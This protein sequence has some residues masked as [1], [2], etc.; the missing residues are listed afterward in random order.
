MKRLRTLAIAAFAALALTALA[1][2]PAAAGSHGKVHQHARGHHHR[3]ATLTGPPQTPS[4]Q[5]TSTAAISRLSGGVRPVRIASG[6]T[7][8]AM[9]TGSWQHG[10]DDDDCQA[11]ADTGNMWQEKGDYLSSQGD[12]AGADKAYDS[13]STVAGEANAGGCNLFLNDNAA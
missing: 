11:D 8:V 7:V 2:G 9:Q 5:S 10:N 12:Q 3:S 6:G 4:S 13:A 1:A